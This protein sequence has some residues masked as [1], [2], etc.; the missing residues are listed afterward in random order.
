MSRKKKQLPYHIKVRERMVKMETN[1][2]S[3]NLC[4]RHGLIET[5]RKYA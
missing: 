5:S 1:I 3:Q 2:K 4:L